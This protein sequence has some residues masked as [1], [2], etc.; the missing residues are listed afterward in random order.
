MCA[1]ERER[2]KNGVGENVP[3]SRILHSRRNRFESSSSSL[4]IFWLFFLCSDSSPFE[5]MQAPILSINR[6]GSFWKRGGWRDG[7]DELVDAPRVL[8]VRERSEVE[9]DRLSP[10]FL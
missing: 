6:G 2:D 1:R 5:L 10:D 9:A 4:S 3:S 8:R 7:L